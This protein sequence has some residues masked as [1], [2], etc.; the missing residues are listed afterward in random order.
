VS[1]VCRQYVE[2]VKGCGTASIVRTIVQCARKLDDDSR[3]R[4]AVSD[5]SPT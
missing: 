2:Y 5:V 1:R 3:V 4:A